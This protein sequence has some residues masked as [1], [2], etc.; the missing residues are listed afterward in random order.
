MKLALPGAVTSKAFRLPI[1]RSD[2][3]VM[4]T[5]D[6]PVLEDQHTSEPWLKMRFQRGTGESLR[7]ST[8]NL[9]DI[10]N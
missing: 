8:G 7:D 1:W 3:N 4:G 9:Q 6:K 10:L 5:R 2:R